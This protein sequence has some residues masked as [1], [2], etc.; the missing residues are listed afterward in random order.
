[1]DLLIF[2][3]I[4]LFGDSLAAALTSMDDIC[5]RAVCHVAEDVAPKVLEV[6]PDLVLYDMS[7]EAAFVEVRGVAE[8]VPDIPIIAIALNELPAEVIACA[9]AGIAAYVPRDVSIDDLEE[10]MRMTLR[11]EASCHPKM[12]ACLMRELRKRR[13][14]PEPEAM[15]PLTR[16]ES[17]VLHLVGRGLANKE[18]A[19]AL[20]LSVSTVKAHLHSI[21][22]KLR[23]RGR[24][25]AIARLRRQPWLGRPT[26]SPAAQD[27]GGS[28]S[29]SR[30][31]DPASESGDLVLTTRCRQ[32]S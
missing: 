4:R 10:L 6:E 32:M 16:R 5:V 9:D 17:E 27:N 31:L 1:M 21:F 14:V 26:K 19:T 29:P 18:V 8:V 15:E 28:R 11:G 3:P 2:T 22:A 30:G 24:G 25:E 20:Y 23:V 13:S 12:V 7:A